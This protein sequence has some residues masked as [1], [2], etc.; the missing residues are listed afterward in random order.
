MKIRTNESVVPLPRQGDVMRKTNA[1]KENEKQLF[2][3]TDSKPVDAIYL[4][5]IDWRM[6]GTHGTPYG[7]GE[8]C[9]SFGI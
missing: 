2:H 7:Q 9:I 5:N 8:L 1:G 6:G 4:Q 3:G